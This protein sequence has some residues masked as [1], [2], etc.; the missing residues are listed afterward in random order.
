[1]FAREGSPGKRGAA[2]RGKSFALMACAALF[3]G[4]V[5]ADASEKVGRT[6]PADDRLRAVQPTLRSGFVAVD[7]IDG[8]GDGYGVGADCTGPDC[9]DT[10]ILINSG[11][12]EACNGVNDKCCNG[13]DDNCNGQTDENA[14]AF[15][16]DGTAACDG[17]GNDGIA[18]D[19]PADCPGGLCL[20]SSP[21]YLQFGDYPLGTQCV[22]GLGICARFGSVVCKG[23][24]TGGACN[25]VPGA[26]DPRDEGRSLSDPSVVDP[27]VVTCFDHLDN[28]CDGFVDHGG[29]D[30]NNVR[31]D[32]DCTT[33]EICDGFDNDNDGTADDGLGLG[34]ACTVGTGACLNNGTIVCDG[35]GLTKCNAVAFPPQSENVPGG[36]RCMDGL[37]ND[38]DSAIDLADSGCQ[39]AEKCDGKDNDGDGNVDED[40]AD[41]GSACT[42]GQGPCQT[43]GVKVCSGNKLST[44][45]DAVAL[46]GSQEGPSGITCTDGIDN[47]C[48]GQADAADIDCGGLDL[49]VTCA[50]P[51]DRGRPGNDCTGWH[52]IQFEATGGIVAPTVTAELVAIDVD[53]STLDVL[54]V[55]NGERAHLASRI[56]PK[57]WK[58]TTKS[59][60]RGPWHEMFAPIPMLRVTAQDGKNTVQAF[61]SNIPYLDV[62]QPANSVVSSGG[63]DT[64][65][66]A[67]IPMVD[68][69]SLSIRVDGVDILRPKP[70]GLGIRPE[71][72]FPGGPFSGVVDVNGTA[73]TV[74]DLMV[75]SG[76]IDE[77]ASNTLS[78]TLSG[79]GCGGH[80]VA[81]DGE[82][83]PSAFPKTPGR[84]TDSCHAD[85]VYDKG[86]SMV[87]KIDVTDPTPG[88]V[89]AGGPTHVV[90]EVCHGLAIA[91]ANINGFPIDVSNPIVTLGN[92]TDAGDSYKVAFDVMVP[93]T[94]L[95]DAVDTH[96][97]SAGSFTKGSNRLVA[98]AVD[99]DDNM[100]FDSFF[101]AV[102]P[103]VG[104][105]SA[106]ASIVAADPGVIGRAFVLAITEPGIDTFFEAMKNKNKKCLG[107][108]AKRAIKD[109][110]TERKE[111]DVECD[112][113]TK[114]FINNTD[115][116]DDSF[117]VEVDLNAS[118]TPDPREGSI[119]TKINLPQ[120]DI[121]AHWDGYC[122]SGCVCAFGGC[123]CAVC[124]TVDLDGRINQKGMFVAFDVTRDRLLQSGVPRE[125]RQPLDVTFDLGETDPNDFTHIGG[126][127][128]IGCLLGF[129]LDVLNFL[130]QV[131]TFG[132]WDPG[133]GTIEFEMTADDIKEKLGS[134]DGD[135]FDT[136]FAKFENKDLPE[137]GT[138][139]RDSKVSDA[140]ITNTGL[141]VSIESN[142]APEPSEIDPAAPAIAGTPLKNA[143]IPIPPILDAAGNPVGHVTIAISDDVFNQLFYSMVMT[144]RL[145]TQ[146]ETTR[147]F[148]NFIP[149]DCSTITDEHKRARCIGMRSTDTCQRFCARLDGCTDACEA[150][151]P[152]G[153]VNDPL[154]DDRR[155]CCR[156]ARIRRNTNIN[157][158]STLIL[159][160]R[161]HNPPK[162]LID[163][164]PATSGVEVVLQ[165]D[166]IS[167][168]LVAD[169][170]GNG[171]L[172]SGS[173]ESIPDCSLGDLD[174]EFGT[175]STA[176]T[177]CILWEYCATVR[178][179]LSLDVVTNPNTGR[180]R[181][182][183]NFLS[184]D[185]ETPFGVVC[186][187]PT[188]VPELGF[189]NDESGRTETMDIL[190]GKLRDHTP[191]LD[192]D[193]LGL[194]GFVEFQRD[195]IIAIETDGNPD[196]NN[197]FFD[198]IGITGNI[199]PKP[200][201]PNA[202]CEEP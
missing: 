109:T 64:Q 18:C 80:I 40:F 23:D 143:P 99:V 24:G 141:A 125:Q 189:F 91:S 201:D 87:F 115:L 188:D 19:D 142:F 15:T 184:L 98:Q 137:F 129:F 120:I 112:P 12:S 89:T 36:V 5:I 39:E 45:C 127:I 56:S 88:E 186:G 105:P 118:G 200:V 102:G 9:D 75:S 187:G 156:A 57:D 68:P 155:A 128:D 165:Y 52:R 150:A 14:T 7:C 110:P 28:D 202:G 103:I 67:A 177:E 158:G 160:G 85:D 163:D 2:Y 170:D 16:R 27:T 71:T 168:H 94:N 136:D 138:R 8:D 46:S 30:E 161:I 50:L 47:D 164:D 173:L 51:Y 10:N 179:N 154:D 69:H 44:V 181:I 81:I 122:E 106:V 100:T 74:T 157:V 84:P 126:E 32:T 31:H 145:K 3:T 153:G 97:G 190:E 195:R 121:T 70:D 147:T 73:V 191:P 33:A 148:G 140:A 182:K 134:M 198:F 172:N 192:A 133:L 151:Y 82:W 169:R 54:P 117:S 17:G 149:D 1:M 20:G 178:L 123:A 83:R 116:H 55:N 62:I 60:S 194:G 183:F 35:S 90:G 48:D 171:V 21:T 86:I 41:L 185:R 92:G 77:M 199:V 176:S 114:M 152:Y 162:M 49:A 132:L 174:L 13:V 130:G 78:M 25:A 4:G 166:Q 124:V 108:R 26:P 6:R 113:P 53:G 22:S 144:G 63:G 58:W 11:M 96:G 193:G 72:D 104:A 146:F 65:V 101:F 95:R 119:H 66:L 29:V 107:D 43:S 135:P 76:A 167:L 34:V 196:A 111:I 139:Q 37:D 197:A 180:D 61:C 131:I 38:C 175:Q 59:N 42:A 79:L 93:E 159:N